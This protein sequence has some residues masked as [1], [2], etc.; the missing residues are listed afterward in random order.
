MA[1]IACPECGRQVSDQAPSC[2][3][4]GVRI[5]GAPQVAPGQA[6]ANVVADEERAPSPGFWRRHKALPW[7]IGGLALLVGGL[8][9]LRAV[10]PPRR[11]Q[12]GYPALPAPSGTPSA[13]TPAPA[14][15]QPM[16]PI[17]IV[18]ESVAVNEDMWK[19]VGFRLA[20]TAQVTIE[21]QGHEGPAFEV[22]TI[23][24]ADIGKWEAA[25]RQGKGNF[26]YIPD[27][28]MSGGKYMRESGRLAVGNYYVIIENTDLGETAPPMNFDDDVVR[29]SV[30][31]TVY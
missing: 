11:T 19:A 4:C 16:P 1:L 15:D 26:E 9:I 28:S 30:K 17:L 27:F 2:P 24:E 29:A 7:L 21:V 10:L 14:A 5:A 20:R 23:E 12:R 13:P 31:V 8:L 25:V 6:P 22:K 18:D 3:G